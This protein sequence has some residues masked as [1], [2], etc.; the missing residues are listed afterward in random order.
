MQNIKDLQ[1]ALGLSESAA[2]LYTAALQI[3]SGTLTEIA[4]RGEV[5]RTVISNPLNELLELGLLIKQVQGKRKHYYPLSPEEWPSVLEKRKLLAQEISRTLL[6]QL[7][8]PGED[9]QVRWHSGISGIQS[10]IRGFLTKHG[11]K[12]FK[13]FENS[14]TYYYMGGR[15][16]GEELIGIRLKYGSKNKLIGVLGND[17]EGW[18]REHLKY[19]EEE[20]RETVIVSAKEYPIQANI[21]VVDDEVLIFEYKK[22]PF[23]LLINNEVLAQ[24][25]GSIHDMIWDRYRA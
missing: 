9:L 11:G 6:Q 20:L 8:I 16:F 1:L 23:A 2:K 13:Q 15:K 7:V 4:R 3:G 12:Q 17:P 5:S 14:D 18:W 21:A 22:K 24:T 10:A 19:N 25:I